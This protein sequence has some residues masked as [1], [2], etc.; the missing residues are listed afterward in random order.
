MRSRTPVGTR[1]WA[2]A[3]PWASQ[4]TRYRARGDAAVRALPIALATV[5]G[6]AIKALYDDRRVTARRYCPS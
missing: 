6:P 3:I 1:F 2:A 5:S 4:P